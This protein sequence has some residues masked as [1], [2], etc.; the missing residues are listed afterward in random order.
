MSQGRPPRTLIER[1]EDRV[2]L[3]TTVLH[4]VNAG[5]P[6]AA[7][8]PAWSADT[9]AAPSPFT[10]AAAA[11]S[12]TYKTTA[13]IDLSHPSIPAGT[14]MSV[15]QDER[16][17]ERL[18]ATMQWDFPV[19]ALGAGQQY[20]VRLY[21]AEIYPGAFAAGARQFDVLLEGQLVL[22][23][24]DAFVDAGGGNKGVVK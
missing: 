6:A 22:D 11:T 21:F 24:Y 13:A 2:F 5:G 23:N 18:G 16:Y 12:R 4:R 3:S 1:L 15:F 10:N 17:D 9:S 14:P 20:E 7:G 8:T 19:A